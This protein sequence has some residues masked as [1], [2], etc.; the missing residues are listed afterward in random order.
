MTSSPAAICDVRGGTFPARF[1]DRAGLFE[2][3]PWWAM[4]GRG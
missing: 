2:I 1:D 3:R 4:P